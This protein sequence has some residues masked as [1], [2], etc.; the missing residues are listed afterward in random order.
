MQKYRYIC[1]FTYIHTF[2]Y[3][4]II[5]AYHSPLCL[6]VSVSL[7]Q[8]LTQRYQEFKGTIILPL[9]QTS[10]PSSFDVISYPP[11]VPPRWDRPHVVWTTPPLNSVYDHDSCLTAARLG[12]IPYPASP[13]QGEAYG[14]PLHQSSYLVLPGCSPLSLVLERGLP[15]LSSTMSRQLWTS[16]LSWVTGNPISLVVIHT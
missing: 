11:Y 7:A 12:S 6:S 1:M 15:G 16:S 4:V 3:P 13:N 5:V 14:S 9:E 2:M 8:S 10:V